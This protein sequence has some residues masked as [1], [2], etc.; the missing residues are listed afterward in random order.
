[1]RFVP[2]KS[3]GQQAVLMLHKTREQFVKQCTMNINAL[4]GQL[5][6]FG[7]TAAKGI[8]RIEELFEKVLND[9]S[10]PAP[11]K[12]A[13]QQIMVQIEAL[14]KSIDALGQEIAAHCAQ[15]ESCQLLDSIPG[16]GIVTASAIVASLPDAAVFKS[17][18]DF[19]AFLG[20]TPRQ[21][22]TGGKETLGSITKQGNRYI[23]KLL[24]VGA[25]SLLSVLKKR[26]GALADWI[27]ALLAKKPARL[28]T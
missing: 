14:D 9:T 24:V 7:I 13:V 26:K 12:L 28:V 10:L 3:R 23:R 21:N 20:L 17:G 1:M 11:A 19:S 15:N 16:V 22:S 8:G 4:R 18:R 6:E 2:V 27:S 5:A 25:T